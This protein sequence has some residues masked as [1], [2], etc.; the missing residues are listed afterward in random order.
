METWE[1]VMLG[2]SRWQLFKGLAA[3]VGIVSIVSLALIYFVPAPPSKVIMATA[4][5]G[6]TFEYYGRQYRE[7]FARSNVEL[8]LRETAGA[9]ENLELPHRSKKNG[10][11][12]SS[13]SAS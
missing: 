9:T 1:I 7:T 4:F 8:E 11:F 10:S 3:A 5:K 2:F 13:A 12:R 6:S